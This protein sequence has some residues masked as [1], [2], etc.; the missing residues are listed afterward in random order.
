MTGQLSARIAILWAG[1]MGAAGIVLGAAAAHLPDAT[2]LASA[3][4]MLLFHA[5]AILSIPLL[6]DRGLTQRHLAALATIAL[7]LGAA[8]FAGDLAAR[9]YLGHG[10]FPM[11]APSGGTLMIAGWLMLG[12]S[13]LF[14]RQR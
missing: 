10:L 2:R 7:G 11:A 5:P 9:Q 1:L 8:L 12:L 3:S 14:A 6:S 4:M 13:G